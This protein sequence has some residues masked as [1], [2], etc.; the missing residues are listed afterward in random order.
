[1]GSTSICCP[2]FKQEKRILLRIMKEGDM[3]K[4]GACVMKIKVIYFSP[5][6]TTKKLALQVGNKLKEDLSVTMEEINLTKPAARG[7]SYKIAN[8]DILLLAIPVY[9]GRIPILLEETVKKI[10]GDKTKAIVLAVYGNR[11]Y[12][13]ALLEMKDLLTENDFVVIAAAAFIGEHSFSFKLAAKRPDE[14]DILVASDFAQ[15][16]AEKINSKNLPPLAI[17]GNYPYKERSASM[18]LAPKTNDSCN[19]CMICFNNCPTEAISNSNP[20]QIAKEKCLRCFACV[21]SCPLSAKYFDDEIIVN[22]I[23]FLESNFMARKEPEFF[24]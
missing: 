5:T 18:Q 15:K 9:G 13:D 21:K 16:I 2:F 11:D 20:K 22:A 8:E 23:A 12:D 3:F 19:A 24:V 1:M 17:K 7:Q 6:H 4:R 10:T 14:T